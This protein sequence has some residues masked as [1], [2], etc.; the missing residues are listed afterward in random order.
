MR[1]STWS[2]MVQ[3]LAML[4]QGAVQPTESFMSCLP[5][6]KDDEEW[7]HRVRVVGMLTSLGQLLDMFDSRWKL[8]NVARKGQAGL[9]QLQKRDLFEIPATN[10]IDR[11]S[12]RNS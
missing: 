9:Y 6:K 11:N 1:V 8:V 7:S 3:A 5:T 2:G 10:V 12:Q 4:K